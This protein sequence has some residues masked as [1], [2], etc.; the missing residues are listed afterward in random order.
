MTFLEKR[1]QARKEKRNYRLKILALLLIILSLAA[2]LYFS[3]ASKGMRYQKQK[4]YDDWGSF[5]NKPKRK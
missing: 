2:A 1:L 4:T 3:T 5:K